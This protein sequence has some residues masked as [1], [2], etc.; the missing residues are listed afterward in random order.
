MEKKEKETGSDMF[1][2]F[3]QIMRLMSG[4]VVKTRFV[5]HRDNI[6]PIIVAVVAN[7]IVKVRIKDVKRDIFSSRS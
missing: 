1:I 6:V 7:R 2:D 3:P 5:G 4:R